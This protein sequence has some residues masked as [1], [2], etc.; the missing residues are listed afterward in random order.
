M[1]ID[2]FDYSTR[3]DA[4]SKCSEYSRDDETIFKFSWKSYPEII[5]NETE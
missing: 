3:L 1:L 5:L 2:V 4:L